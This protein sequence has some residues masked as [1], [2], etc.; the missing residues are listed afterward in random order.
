M[1]EILNQVL[2]ACRL[3]REL[4]SSLPHIAN[5]PNVLLAS[6]E[7]VSLA[8][9]KV[10]YDLRGCLGGSSSSFDP[11]GQLIIGERIMEDWSHLHDPDS[12]PTGQMAFSQ[13]GLDIQVTGAAIAAVEFAD[14]GGGGRLAGGEQEHAVV[15]VSEAETGHG[16]RLGGPVGSTG[17]RPSRRRRDSGDTRTV[18]IPALR[19]G[20]LELP[21]DDGY[22]WR[23]YGQKAILGSKFPRSYFRCTHRNFYGCK[24]KRKVQRLD[25]DPNTYEI[26]YCGNH[27]CQTS[28]T[29]LIL[30][31]MTPTTNESMS[32]NVAIM[33]GASPPP[34]FPLSTS[35]ELSSWFLKEH[36]SE[37]KAPSRPFLSSHEVGESSR[38]HAGPSEQAAPPVRTG[39]EGE[40]SVA[41]LADAMF[42]SGSS[43]NSMDTIFTFKT[44]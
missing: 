16:G 1:D 36:E 12:M 17:Q 13:F 3:S 22:T 6:C 8:F 25:A 34:A 2:Q 19:T 41:D 9:N 37:G 31:S 7:Q 33:T 44:D 39:R 18:R 29:P 30:P 24:A 40:G 15:V 43:S 21:P 11:T 4:E 28:P 38:A 32:G 14:V 23:K 10:V 42:N 35:I 26:T 27:T 20:N 5:N